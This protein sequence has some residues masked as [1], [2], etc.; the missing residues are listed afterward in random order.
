MSAAIT[1]YVDVNV[2]LTGVAADAFGFGRLMGIFDH[3]V[4]ANRQDGPYTS[5]AEAVAAGFTAA[6]EPEVHAWLTAVFSQDDAID[7][8]LIGRQDVG[9]ADWTATLTA[10]EAADPGSWYI[11]TIESRAEA[12]IL[13]AAAFIEATGSG[14]FPKILIAQSSDAAL[15]AGTAGNVGED[16]Q[17]VSYQRTALFY[18]AF[19]DAAAG[20]VPADGYLDGAI[21]SSGGGLDLD[22]IGGVGTWAYRQ[23]EGVAFDSITEL[24]AS[25]VFGYDANIFGR[26]K[27]LNFTS[28]GTMSGGRFIDVTT[29]LDWLRLRIEEEILSE[30]V[31]A[32]TKIPFTNAGINRI[33][34]AVQRVYDRGV[35]FGHLSPD[36]LPTLAVP[37][38]TE[39]SSA[40]KQNRELTLNG[41]AVL[42]GAIHK[43]TININV[44][45]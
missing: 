4:T 39:V 2:T 29:S 6:A 15:L 16:L 7:S 20:T 12:D 14:S 1:E 18:H 24:E 41:N 10:V 11:T 21:A 19:D 34:A 35:A 36:E 44:Q 32:Q 5:L 33:A 3:S 9:D 13:L 28:K 27:G 25:T 30:F 17:A 8:V 45:Q 22:G 38:V 37:D 40:D 42:A 43:A 26:T 31:G 23:L